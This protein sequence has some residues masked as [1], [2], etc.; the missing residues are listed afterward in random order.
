MAL[1]TIPGR[2]IELGSDAAGDLAYYD[3]S[4]WTRLAKG[5]AT[6]QL[7]VNAGATAPEWITPTSTGDVVQMVYD[8]STRQHVVATGTTNI[9]F[10]DTVPDIGEGD[11]YMNVSITPQSASNILVVQHQ[12]WYSDSLSGGAMIAIF[13]G[14]TCVGAAQYEHPTGSLHSGGDIDPLSA[15]VTMVAGTT[16]ALAITI[17]GSTYQASATLNFNGDKNGSRRFGATPKS[18]LI[19]TEYTP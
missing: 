12:G 10:D 2:A 9:P 16:S 4:K 19:V 14:N 8:S 5:T 1:Q 17:R 15:T 7:A 11:P 18:S 3:G 13:A 6:Q